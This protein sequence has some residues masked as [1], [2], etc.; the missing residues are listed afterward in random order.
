M[1]TATDVNGK[2]IFYV[3]TTMD[4]TY[5]L[6]D[7]NQTIERWPGSS[8]EITI[9]PIDDGVRYHIIAGGR[10]Y[11]YN[12][13][14]KEMMEETYFGL[15]GVTLFTIPNRPKYKENTLAV[16]TFQQINQETSVCKNGYHL[17]LLEANDFGI[18]DRRLIHLKYERTKNEYDLSPGVFTRTQYDISVA[19]VGFNYYLSEIDLSDDGS[20]LALADNHKIAVFPLNTDGSVNVNSAVGSSYHVTG[21]NAAI[22]G[23][24]FIDNARLAY[25]IF[26]ADVALDT[27]VDRVKIWN[28]ATNQTQVFANSQG[29][30]RSNI[31][32]TRDGKLVL[33]AAD[34]LYQLNPT[35]RTISAYLTGRTLHKNNN[36]YAI[37]YPAGSTSYYGIYNLPDQLDGESNEKINLD[38]VVYNLRVN[39][40]SGGTVNWSDAAHGLTKKG[41]GRIVVLG[42]ID[43]TGTTVPVNMDN[44]QFLFYTDAFMN[45]HS[46]NRITFRGCL[47][48]ALAS[49]D[50]DMWKGI[51]VSNVSRANPPGY[52]KM[53]AHPATTAYTRVQDALIG[54]Y[55]VGRDSRL[56]ITGAH[57]AKNE[58]DVRILSHIKN[59]ILITNSYFTAL[60]L[61]GKDKGSSN[62]FGDGRRRTINNIEIIGSI[63]TIGGTTAST[64][65]VIS[66][67]QSGIMAVNSTLNLRQTEIK[68]AK[69]YALDYNAG[70]QS[71]PTLTVRNCYIHDVFRGA[72]VSNCTN[73]NNRTTFHANRFANTSGYAIEY[74]DNPGGILVIGNQEDTTLRNTFD[75]CNWQAIGCFN[76]TKPGE[77]SGLGSINIS[78]NRFDRHPYAGA[79]FVGEATSPKTSYKSLLITRNKIG[80]NGRLGTDITLSQVTGLNPDVPDFKEKRFFEENFRID[81]NHIQFTNSINLWANGIHLSN[82]RRLNVLR[83]QVNS[84]TWGDYRPSALRMAE[85]PWNLV[86]QNHFQ[87]GAGGR[88]QGDAEL[89]NLYCNTLFQ[90]VCGWQFEQSRLRYEYKGVFSINQHG[91][92]YVIHGLALKPGDT[93]SR[94]NFYEPRV[95]T[96]GHVSWGADIAMYTREINR[97]KWDLARNAPRIPKVGYPYLPVGH[98]QTII[99]RIDRKYPPACSSANSEPAEHWLAGP[100]E[101]LE[102]HLYL[103]TLL[104]WKIAHRNI[105]FGEDSLLALQWPSLAAL[106]QIE[107]TLQ[108]QDFQSARSLLSAYHPS[109]TWEAEFK[110]VYR[111]WADLNLG[112]DT[113]FY[114]APVCWQLDTTWAGDGTYVVDSF[115]VDTSWFVV[116]PAALSDSAK[117]VLMP[118]AR[119]SPLRQSPAA[120]AARVLLFALAEMQF[121]DSLPP[122][123]PS[124]S[125]WVDTLCLPPSAGLKVEICTAA[126]APTGIHAFTGADGWFRVDGARMRMLDSNTMYYLR[127]MGPDSVSYTTPADRWYHLAYA[128]PHLLGCGEGAA[129]AALAGTQSIWAERLR[130]YPVPASQTLHVSGLPA[131]WQL[132]LQDLSG[133]TLLHYSGAEQQ[134]QLPVQGYAP[135][136]YLLE[137]SSKT[138]QHRHVVKVQIQ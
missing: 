115:L 35:S 48:K 71:F 130:I 107:R 94:H 22:G 136:M 86:N 7:A 120:Y 96:F 43:F 116:P 108:Q 111:V 26:N 91:Y 101:N 73:E 32:K 97:H 51:R 125:G 85:G 5:V 67:G 52:L 3:L 119:K 41:S 16:R 129:P 113:Q 47:L 70:K 74:R 55:Y 72:R 37:Y 64:G 118:I 82:A 4:S 54:L 66:A 63:V 84:G 11:S 61:L 114:R 25:T 122:F 34:G 62:G 93:I 15:P 89:S 135:G 103:D 42:S 121:T 77:T 44:M 46:A 9:V 33:G 124:I 98:N 58:T 24:E 78:N 21:K 13:A 138:S 126:G 88:I 104:D 134:V 106:V 75:N 99:H 17:Y 65:N 28:F 95:G 69:Q 1:N 127:I 49:C 133:R 57:F 31:E 60:P 19:T 50:G 6:N 109:N 131:A 8:R 12:L 18:T 38:E 27:A 83:N 2:L 56:E 110:T 87:G 79:V 68:N 53:E 14:K 137:L 59:N 45:M 20:R 112:R 30:A 90:S 10:I 128:G 100:E 40:R 102:Q 80:L 132:R 123:Y 23:L 76:N 81:S 36:R 92:D 29:Y 117:G 39:I 105:Q